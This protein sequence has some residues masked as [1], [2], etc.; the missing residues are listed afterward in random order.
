M[1]D[2]L[3]VINHTAVIGAYVK[4]LR[5]MLDDYIIEENRGKQE[6]YENI[7]NEIYLRLEELEYLATPVKTPDSGITAEALARLQDLDEERHAEGKEYEDLLSELERESGFD[8]LDAPDP[9]F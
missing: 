7:I 2:S 9:D 8:P 1:F 4:V 3:L 6:V 5:D